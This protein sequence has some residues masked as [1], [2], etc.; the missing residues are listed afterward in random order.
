MQPSSPPPSPAKKSLFLGGHANKGSLGNG[1]LK[2]FLLFQEI[3]LE[4]NNTG[5]QYTYRLT[6]QKLV[7][8]VSIS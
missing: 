8:L 6:T 7:M 2:R 1:I 3:A 4:N 5:N